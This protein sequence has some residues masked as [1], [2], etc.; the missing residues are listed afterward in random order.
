MPA[1]SG[2]PYGKVGQGTWVDD[3]QFAFGCRQ[4]KIHTSCG[5]GF[6]DCLFAAISIEPAEAYL[7]VGLDGGQNLQK[8]GLPII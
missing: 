5:Y 3:V 8:P 1:S 2:M 7:R 6:L 4:L